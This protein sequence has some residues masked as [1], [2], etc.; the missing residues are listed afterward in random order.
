LYQCFIIT[1]VA[2]EYTADELLV[3]KTVFEVMDDDKNETIDGNELKEMLKMIGM[4]G[5]A[6]V[7]HKIDELMYVYDVD[8]SDTVDLDEWLLMM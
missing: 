6:A 7:E 1:K 8:E 3:A 4:R 5:E 2:S